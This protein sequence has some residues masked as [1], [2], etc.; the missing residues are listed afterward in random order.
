MMDLFLRYGGDL[1]TVIALGLM[2]SMSLT[3]FRRVPK[4]V[5]VPAP[6][7]FSGAQGPRAP[8]AVALTLTVVIAFFVGAALEILAWGHAGAD[9]AAVMIFAAR[10]LIASL[11]ALVHVTYLRAALTV[12]EAEGKLRP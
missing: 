9:P 12:L 5:A 6:W 11:F 7:N 10:A 4:G 1:L 3:A 2:A 8:R